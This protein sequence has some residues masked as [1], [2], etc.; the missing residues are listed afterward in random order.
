MGNIIMM[1]TAVLQGFGGSLY[2]DVIV[3]E[4]LYSRI[5]MVIIKNTMK[6]I[7]VI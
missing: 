1:F 6:L 7:F 4:V 5:P 3:S 2:W